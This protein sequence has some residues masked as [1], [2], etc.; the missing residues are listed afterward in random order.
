MQGCRCQL[1][2]SDMHQSIGCGGSSSFM[3]IHLSR[4][5]EVLVHT[6][7]EGG[8]HSGSRFLE[9]GLLGFVSEK[10]SRSLQGHLI[11]MQEFHAGSILVSAR[12]W[13]LP[14]R[15]LLRHK[16]R[17]SICLWS[18][19]R[20]FFG[21]SSLLSPTPKT[22]ADPT[23]ELSATWIS[24]LKGLTL[25]SSWRCC[26]FFQANGSLVPYVLVSS[27]FDREPCTVST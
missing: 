3:L 25:S 8:P 19:A 24:E 6:A 17:C 21:L 27:M 2:P 23:A 15:F 20:A 1:R 4:L 14:L 26:L 7:L 18:G 16:N 9:L 12:K 5:M 13:E 10:Q 11:K 22:P